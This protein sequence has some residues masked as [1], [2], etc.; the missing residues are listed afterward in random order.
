M[1]EAAI[2][3]ALIEQVESSLPR[4]TRLVGC[5]VRVGELEHLEGGVMDAIWQASIRGTGLEGARLE[6]EREPLRVRC[7]GCGDEFTPED[8]AILLC[9]ACGAVRPEVLSGTGVTLRS[10]E[11]EEDA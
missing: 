9:P 7:G 3:Q 8:K 6:I 5:R 10:L 1:H 2:T 4:G 11:V